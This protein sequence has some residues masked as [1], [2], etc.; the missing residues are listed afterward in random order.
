MPM[1]YSTLEDIFFYA[2]LF[3][4]TLREGHD[5]VPPSVTLTG[6]HRRNRVEFSFQAQTLEEVV[7]LAMDFCVEQQYLLDDIMEEHDLTFEDLHNLVEVEIEANPTIV[8]PPHRLADLAIAGQPFTV[9]TICG[10]FLVTPVESGDPDDVY[11]RTHAAYDWARD[12]EDEG[13][14]SDDLS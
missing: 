7:E 4:V 3:D 1:P 9:R 13:F 10:D 12:D 5:D 2:D 14:V 11:A 8:I 6:W